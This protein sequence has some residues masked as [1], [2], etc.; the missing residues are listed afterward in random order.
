MDRRSTLKTLLIG[1]VAGGVAGSA[2]IQ[3]CKTDVVPEPL[4]NNISVGRTPEELT[5]D[6]SLMEA[7]FFSEEELHTIAVLCDIILPANTTSG[8][9]T[10][11]GVHDFIAFIVKDM[12]YHQL[13]LRGGLMWL[14]TLSNTLFNKRFTYCAAEEQLTMVEDIAYPDKVKPGFEYGVKFF[15]LLRDLVLTGYYTSQMGLKDLGYKGNVPNIWDGVP[16]EVLAK[17]GL[18]YEE[19]WLAK[20]VDQNK[21]NDIAEWDDQG[22]LIT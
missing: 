4:V 11:A 22:N 15:N 10:D 7:S 2:T 14:D 17:H 1:G 13:P 6:I 9:A 5:R 18:A 16:E 3:G 12:T 19:E 21:R 8:S 20:C